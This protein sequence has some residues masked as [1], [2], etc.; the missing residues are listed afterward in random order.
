MQKKAE[1]IR[2]TL[3]RNLTPS[4]FGEEKVATQ[5]AR[6][7]PKFINKNAIK[8]TKTQSRQNLEIVITKFAWKFLTC[9][10][11]AT[12]KAGGGCPHMKGNYSALALVNSKQ[13][14]LFKNKNLA[15]KRNES[16]S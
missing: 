1:N 7:R 4:E 6:L 14:S 8:N 11:P 16:K 5:Q 9:S 15:S 2:V 13:N 10:H 3:S 12:A